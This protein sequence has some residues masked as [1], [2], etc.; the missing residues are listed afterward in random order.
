MHIAARCLPSKMEEKKRRIGSWKLLLYGSALSSLLSL[1]YPRFFVASFLFFTFF[2][3]GKSVFSWDANYVSLTPISHCQFAGRKRY[4]NS[5]EEKRNFRKIFLDFFSTFFVGG[6][7]DVTGCQKNI[8]PRSLSDTSDSTWH[9]ANNP[10]S[11]RE[12]N[13]KFQSPTPT[14]K[15]P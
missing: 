9:R 15:L 11:R 14:Y 13:R 1:W 10:E 8:P 5:W 4:L 12:T 2:L 3:S 7:R 6:K